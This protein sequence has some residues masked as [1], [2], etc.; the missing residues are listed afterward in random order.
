MTDVN[1]VD[2]SL[3]LALRLDRIEE[4]VRRIEA[5]VLRLD[6]TKQQ[7]QTKDFFTT[8]E[9]AKLLGKRPFTVREW[10]R[11]G[12]VN[13]EKTHAG[14]GAEPEWRISKEEVLRI[15]NDGLLPIV[16]HWH[17][18]RPSCSHKSSK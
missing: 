12:R 11:L 5:I 18:T 8:A 9:V 14:R 13:A 17:A 4:A 15:Q 3:T 1:S 16:P 2:T 6:D 7:L 10:A